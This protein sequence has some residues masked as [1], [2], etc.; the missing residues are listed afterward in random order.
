MLNKKYLFLVFG[1]F[2]LIGSLGFGSAGL[3]TNLVSYYKL[4]ESSGVVIDELGTYN[5]TN[6][7]GTAQATGIIEKAYDF[8]TNDRIYGTSIDPDD[9]Y[10]SGLSM[11]GWF[12]LDFV[13][14]QAFIGWEYDGSNGQKEIFIEA[15]GQLG[16]H[17]G[18]AD[19]SGAHSNVGVN[20][21]ISTG[22]WYF[23]TWTHGAIKDRIYVNGILID[24]W[25]IG[26]SWTT[27]GTKFMMAEGG[28][29][30][31]FE[32]IID[33]VGIWGRE[34]TQTEI[35][36]LYN[37]GNGLTYP[38]G[39][40]VGSSISVTLI[41]PT[42]DT[43]L[44]DVGTNFTATFAPTDLNLTN[45]TYNVWNSTGL[46]NSTTVSL[47]GN[48]TVNET[49]FIDNFGMGDYFWGVYACGDNSTGFV[50]CSWAANNYTFEVGA[51]IINQTYNNNTYETLNESFTA[52]VQSIPGV[53]FYQA[54]LHYNGTKYV[55]S[56]TNMGN[57]TYYL[58]KTID[59]PLVNSTT[60]SFFWQFVFTSPVQ[61]TQN[62]TLI[63]QTINPIY[64]G[65]CNGTYTDLSLNI[66]IKNEANFSL[67]NSSL[68]FNA[69][70]YLG[71]GTLM[72]TLEFKNTDNN[73]S[74]FQFCI[75]P[76]TKSFYIEDIL[77][78]YAPDHE[79]REYFLDQAT[80][81][82]A[83]QNLAL[84]LLPTVDTSVF[85]VRVIDEDE[86]NLEGVFVRV[87][88]WDIGTNNFYTI[89]MIKTT[90]DGTGII[91]LRLNDAWYRYQLI[92]NDLLIKTTEPTKESSTERVIQ[93]SLS[94]DNP[95]D[96]FGNIDYDLNYDNDTN[97]T[98]LTYADT[99][100]SVQTGCL[101][102]IEL[103]GL[104]KN[105]VY[106]SCVESTSGVLSYP[107]P[108]DGTYII[109]A[110]FILTDEYGS[111]EKVVDEIFR[112]GEE[113]RFGTI[114]V[115]GAFASLLLIGTAGLIGVSAGSI[116][117]GIGLIVA[118]LV[119]VNLIGW[120]NISLSV[121]ISLVSIFILILFNMGKKQ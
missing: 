61:R 66:T 48:V 93:V 63:N 73:L 105:E 104:G 92:Y 58:S 1:I 76:S 45:A 88:R 99:S 85:T 118:S 64:F 74:N 2:L 7:G 70:Y 108:T 10:A 80:L 14:A 83:V 53:S 46:F 79:R 120:L 21:L 13:D 72:K 27:T 51:S 47:S 86:N 22:N 97:I 5:L 112:Q 6:D 20:G 12:K 68:E 101:K 18:Y 41:S 89:G 35:T 57:D 94:E 43:L 77:S 50:N 116:P 87:Q 39:E 37:S 42:N 24:E 28:D 82:S 60:V 44:T 49:L 31:W 17:Y 117:L 71:T 75:S 52:Y 90:S 9:Y 65:L 25:N 81:T 109:R 36:K 34:L 59:M 102:I 15:D 121:I 19:G 33:E 54:Y 38:F 91:N 8:T 96:Q 26:G 3:N 84:Y 78:Y 56:L 23:I 11:S 4:E 95:Y 119:I 29:P 62:T 16:V 30:Q 67:I 111:I 115:S 107:V 32:G 114:G 40:S 100:G 55:S 113:E 103:T 110:I 98:S 106:Y 69:D